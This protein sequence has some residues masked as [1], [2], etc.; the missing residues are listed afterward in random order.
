M[1][2]EK[3]YPLPPWDMDNAAEKLQLLENDWNSLDPD[4]AAANYATEAQMRF[5][6]S[7]LNGRDEIKQFL[8]GKW[9]Q[10]PGFKIKLNLWGALKGRMAVTFEYEWHN[11]E[12]QWH[13]SYGVQVFQFDDNGLVQMNFASYN[14]EPIPH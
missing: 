13:R 11:A 12:N 9:Q 14:D 5:G 3:K 8:A 1:E 4:K 2:T 7:F 6:T 10:N